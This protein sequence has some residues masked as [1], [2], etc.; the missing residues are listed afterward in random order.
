MNFRIKVFTVVLVIVAVAGALLYVPLTSG[1]QSSKGHKTAEA[2]CTQIDELELIWWLLNNSQPVEVEGTAVTL[3]RDML[4][5]NT[6]DGQVRIALPEEWT[7][8]SNV[9]MREMLFG[10]YLRVSGNVTVKAL[11]ANIIEKQELRIFFMIGY[12]IS[13]EWGITAYATIP[14]NIET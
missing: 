14:L 7:V 8:G 2:D 13:N 9:V 11:R 10:S 5:V 4:I 12:E 1:H 6:V 3:L